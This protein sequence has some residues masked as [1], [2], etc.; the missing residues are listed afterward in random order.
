MFSAFSSHHRCCCLLLVACYYYRFL[1]LFLWRSSSSKKNPP[2]NVGGVLGCVSLSFPLARV[3]SRSGWDVSSLSVWP[4][5]PFPQCL[6]NG[7]SL[8]SS[9]VHPIHFPLVRGANAKKNHHRNRLYFELALPA[10]ALVPSF[11]STPL[12]TMKKQPK[13]YYNSY[14]PVQAS[15][16]ISFPC[17]PP[18]PKSLS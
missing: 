2:L 13:R 3:G 8:I 5:R 17:P 18:R 15:S 4:G 14:S 1:F 16:F 12:L 7:T 10:R 6:P 11:L 9:F